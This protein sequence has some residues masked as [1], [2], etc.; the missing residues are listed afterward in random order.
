MGGTSIANFTQAA[1]QAQ[2]WVNEL[3]GNLNWDERRSYRLLRCVLQALRDWLPQQ[4]TAD[5]SAQL[6]TLIRGIY[7]EGWKPLE[8]PVSDRSKD[9]FIA[10]IQGAFSDDLLNDPEQAVTAVFRL[11]DRHVS[12]GEI[13]DVRNSMKKTLRDLWPAD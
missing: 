13:E 7:F 12:P 2:H 8:T 3:A 1:Q 5:L 11:L 10:R 6:P 9:E 4:E